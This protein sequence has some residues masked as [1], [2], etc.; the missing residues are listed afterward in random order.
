M[1]KMVLV[2][3]GAVALVFAAPKC[4]YDKAIREYEKRMGK[5][6]VLH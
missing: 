1:K 4:N 5:S 3:L 2:V 6:S